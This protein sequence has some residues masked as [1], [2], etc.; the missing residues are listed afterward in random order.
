[1]NHPNNEIEKQILKLEV[2]KKQ[3]EIKSNNISVAM[4]QNYGKIA[5]IDFE[6]LGLQLQQVQNQIANL[7]K[8]IKELN[9]ERANE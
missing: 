7:E 2:L 4:G 8:Q 3:L 9:S 5:T 1:M 6:S